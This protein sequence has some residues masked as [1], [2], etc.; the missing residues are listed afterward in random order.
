[1]K[2]PMWITAL[3][4]VHIACGFTAFFVAPVVLSLVKGGKQHRRWGRVYFWL[5]AAVAAT[6]LV[7]SLYRP[8]LF[9]T[10]VAVFSFYMA[11][12]GYRVLFRK[13]PEQGEKARMIDWTGAILMLAAGVLLIVLGIV[14]PTPLWARLSLVA[15]AFGITGLFFGVRDIQSF[16]R[17]PKDKNFWWYDHMGGMIGSYIAAVSAFSVVNF[18]FLPPVVRWLWP[19]AIGIPAILIWIRYYRL[20]F[21]GKK[22]ASQAA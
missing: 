8:V 16:L 4:I 9:L 20:K 13:R 19:S 6:A 15:M 11:F 14:K 10:L 22:T 5:M 3:R 7:L 1:M 21:N 17:T 2:D 12:S 18:R